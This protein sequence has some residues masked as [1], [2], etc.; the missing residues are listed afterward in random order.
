MAFVAA[1]SFG[2]W[3]VIAGTRQEP[4]A[5]A[6]F[7]LK[8]LLLEPT[9]GRFANQEA[10]IQR[11]AGASYIGAIFVAPII[12]GVVPSLLMYKY[13]LAPATTVRRFAVLLNA[14]FALEFAAIH[15]GYGIG[16]ILHNLF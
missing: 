16:G 13:Q 14:I 4:S 8:R 7:F 11:V 10:T 9:N 6:Q 2:M 15:G 1:W 5:I 3:L 12:G